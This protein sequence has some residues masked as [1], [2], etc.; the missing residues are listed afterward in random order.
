MDAVCRACWLEEGSGQTVFFSVI[1]AYSGSE[2]YLF[3][4]FIDLIVYLK[5]SIH[6]SQAIGLVDANA[7]FESRSAHC[8]SLLWKAK[9]ALF[10][11]IDLVI[12]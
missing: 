7:Y 8:E 4:L 2:F 9:A 6:D 1:R 5:D 3:L 10:L 12:E 11:P